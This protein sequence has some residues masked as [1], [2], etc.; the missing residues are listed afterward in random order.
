MLLEAGNVVIRILCLE[1]MEIGNELVLEPGLFE[2]Q[3]EASYATLTWSGGPSVELEPSV[4][5]IG[6]RLLKKNANCMLYV[7]MATKL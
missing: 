7:S 5:N 3:V 1:T 4:Q 6:E 2:Y